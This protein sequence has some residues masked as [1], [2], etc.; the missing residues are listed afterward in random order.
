M[1]KLVSCGG[2]VQLEVGLDVA[3]RELYADGAALRELPQLVDLALEVVA[4]GDV[5]KPRRADDVRPFG[6]AADGGDLRRHLAGRQRPAPAGLG[7]LA[8][9]DLDG[10]DAPEGLLGGAVAGG[11]V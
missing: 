4:R 8:E 5:G 10:V 11:G 6:E 1:L 9:L 3:G 2:W 7:R